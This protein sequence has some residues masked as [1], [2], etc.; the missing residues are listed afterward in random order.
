M[1]VIA[2][3]PGYYGKL[4]QVGDRF[5]VADGDKAS[6]FCPVRD[7]GGEPIQAKG[8]GKGKAPKADD[9]V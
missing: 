6:W 1:E 5:A 8:K 3:K 4:R 2:T 9:L 7:E